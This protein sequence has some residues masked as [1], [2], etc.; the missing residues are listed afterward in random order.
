MKGILC[1]LCVL[2][3]LSSGDEDA[4]IKTKMYTDFEGDPCVLLLNRNQTVG[5]QTSAQGVTGVLFLLDTRERVEQFILSPPSEEKIVV[6]SSELINMDNVFDRLNGT[7]KVVGIIVVQLDRPDYFS[8]ESKQPQEDMYTETIDWNT[9]GNSYILQKMPFPIWAVHGS[10]SDQFYEA[11]L[12]NKNATDYPYYAATMVLDMQP[13][14]NS[15]SVECLKQG[16]CAPLGGHSTVSTMYPRDQAKDILLIMS[17]IDSA[18]MFQKTAIGANSDMS[19]A[20]S[21][22]AAIKSLSSMN[23]ESFTLQPVFAMLDG[24]SW[25]Y[26]GS[27]RLLYQTEKDCIEN[28]ECDLDFNRVK[29]IIEMKQVGG[30]G[31]DSLYVH[32]VSAQQLADRIINISS[33]L[34]FN[35]ENGYQNGLP[36]S[37]FTQV[38]KKYPSLEGKGVV[39]TDHYKEY[40]NKFYHSY[41]D[42]KE[43]LN[44]ELLCSAATLLIRTIYSLSNDITVDLNTIEANCSLVNDLIFCLTE[45]IKCDL[46]IDLIPSIA[47]QTEEVII[48][49][50][51]V[52]VYR[53]TT[54]IVYQK[55]IHDYVFD[56]TA[57]QREG[58]C[59][60]DTDCEEGV[61][62]LHGKCTSSPST[63]YYAAVSNA[64][65]LSES[66]EYVI[67][68]GSEPIWTEAYWQP[69]NL[70]LF[71]IG[72]PEQDLY[73]GIGALVELLLTIAAIFLIKKY[74]GN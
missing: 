23:I 72:N 44:P 62:C 35:A 39:I 4:R 21:L 49:T 46:A 16:T 50:H 45:N 27:N 55:F 67:A 73:F 30:V 18:S 57:N 68:D 3:V 25:G 52:S 70:K 54:K 53:E 14:P 41:L 40:K 32:H 6:L 38:I 12:K 65:E 71:L 26:L 33:N 37:S 66:L 13:A 43:N 51:Y 42:G 22:L 10:D 48:P 5:C 59:S 64:I 74:F 19:G 58:D 17:S 36:P 11:A 47:R 15:N 7:E 8:P 56:L 69:P 1:F 29:N 60:A 24:E 61:Q 9:F 31:S 63:K 20:I 28:T 2:I 34:S